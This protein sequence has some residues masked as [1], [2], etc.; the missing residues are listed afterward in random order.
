MCIRDRTE[1]DRDRETVRETETETDTDRDRQ[2]DREKRKTET[3][4]TDIERTSNRIIHTAEMEVKSS[5]RLSDDTRVR[6]DWVSRC[7][8]DGL[9][10][11]APPWQAGNENAASGS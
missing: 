10:L 9:D 3:I 4:E 8:Y 7:A 5:G 6:D 2:T 1:R 11:L